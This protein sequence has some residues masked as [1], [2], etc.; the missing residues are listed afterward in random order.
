MTALHVASKAVRVDVVRMLL[1]SGVGPTLVDKNGWS[2]LSVLLAYDIS[3]TSDWLSTARM[4]IE[5]GCDIGSAEGDVLQQRRGRKRIDAIRVCFQ[6]WMKEKLEG[7]DLTDIP[8]EVFR[9]GAPSVE[10]YLAALTVSTNLVYRHKICVVGPTT[11]GKTSLIKSLTRSESVLE[12]LDTRTVGIDL[13]S[14]SFKHVGTKGTIEEHEVTFWDFAG[15]EVYHSAH[16]VFFSRRTLFLV[17]VDLEAYS[18]FLPDSSGRACVTEERLAEFVEFNVLSWLRLIFCRVPGAKLAFVGTKKDRVDPSHEE[19]VYFDLQVHAE[20]W[21]A[22]VAASVPLRGKR[23]PS[24]K[25]LSQQ[26]QGSLKVA[27]ENW[28]TVTCVDGAAVHDLTR[29]I[30]T[31]LVSQQSRF[32]MPDS[33][34]TVLEEVRK[35]RG[36]PD[37]SLQDRFRKL[38]VLKDEFKERLMRAIPALSDHGSVIDVI[39][40]TLHD[41]GDVI[42]YDDDNCSYPAV[43]HQGILAPEVV[44]DFIREVI[45]HE[46]LELKSLTTSDGKDAAQQRRR[47]AYAWIADHIDCDSWM[48][49]LWERGEVDDGLLTR[50]PCW[51]EL[52]AIDEEKDEMWRGSSLHEKTS[53]VLAIKSLLQ[54]FGLT[55]PSK[56]R[57]H[58]RSN[59][60]IP[61][62]W[63]LQ[64]RRTTFFECTDSE[65]HLQGTAR[66]VGADVGQYEWAYEVDVFGVPSA[67]FEHVV[68]RAFHPDVTRLIAT[69]ECVVSVVRGES[70][71]VVECA[72]SRDRNVLRVRSVALTRELARQCVLFACTAV[73]KEL[74]MYPGLQPHRYSPGSDGE[75]VELDQEEEDDDDDENEDVTWLR[76]RPWMIEGTLDDYPRAPFGSMEGRQSDSEAG[77]EVPYAESRAFQE[78][79]NTE[80]ILPSESPVFDPEYMTEALQCCND[81]SDNDKTVT[82]RRVQIVTC[83]GSLRYPLMCELVVSRA[84]QRAV[85]LVEVLTEYDWSNA[86]VCF[87]AAPKCDLDVS[88]SEASDWLCCRPRISSGHVEILSIESPQHIS[89]NLLSTKSSKVLATLE[90]EMKEMD[91]S[92]TPTALGG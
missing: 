37:M 87:K 6:Q 18:K 66:I 92:S 52:A 35:H 53:R 80:T 31:L 84:N 15:Q 88:V 71:L 22:K 11:W 9:R 86:L 7:R 36:S 41:L 40:R 47:E 56:G 39:M 83:T 19:L 81:D 58:A 89:I 14:H 61:A 46:L 67:L 44:L 64:E 24:T 23:S 2:P 62:Y 78:Q 68:V 5:A 48:A 43:A 57:M 13:F 51:A 55:Y 69:F 45:S 1:D 70:A 74:M 73:E 76:K 21:G 26:I 38:L 16:S 25:A 3:H 4:L 30:Q 60:I 50:L 29:H 59:L 27:I 91:M 32:L 65:L 79:H 82:M 63:K 34:S 75:M 85:Q 10:A 42:W 20:K 12:E 90:C 72:S 54:V 28:I 49:K 8:E 17:V 33:Y 77:S